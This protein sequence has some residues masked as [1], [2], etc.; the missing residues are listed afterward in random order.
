MIIQKFI[1]NARNSCDSCGYNTTRLEGMN[2]HVIVS[3]KI[4]L[5]FVHHKY[6]T[7][8]LTCQRLKVRKLDKGW[9]CIVNN[10]YWS[11]S[12]PTSSWLPLISIFKSVIENTKRWSTTQ[13]SNASLRHKA[14]STKVEKNQSPHGHYVVQDKRVHCSPHDSEIIFYIELSASYIDCFGD[15]WEDPKKFSNLTPN[16]KITPKRPKM[17]L[18][19]VNIKITS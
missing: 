3:M 11:D 19:L 5:F 15:I 16:P 8:F 7:G 12:E 2:N 14:S 6:I 18:R 1:D 13:R 10:W 4:N 9:M 17:T